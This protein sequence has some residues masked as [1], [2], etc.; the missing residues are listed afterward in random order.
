MS[1][2]VHVDH[3]EKPSEENDSDED[4]DDDD[5]DEDDYSDS[6]DEDEPTVPPITPA[7]EVPEDGPYM[8][9]IR[10]QEIEGAETEH[11]R[12]TAGKK[13]WKN[14]HHEKITKVRAACPGENLCS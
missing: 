13:D 1:I 4:D 2:D 11:E 9:Y 10:N 14:H 7:P 12:F 8:R 3:V 5:D 6:E